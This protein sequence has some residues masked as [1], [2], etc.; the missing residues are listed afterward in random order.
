MRKRR[1]YGRDVLKNSRNR[2]KSYRRG[3]IFVSLPYDER[4]PA[5]ARVGFYVF[6]ARV[7]YIRYGVRDLRKE[8]GKF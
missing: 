6:M 4:N 1:P 2:R 5:G 8:S 7:E 3:E